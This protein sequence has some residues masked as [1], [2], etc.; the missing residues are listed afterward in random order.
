MCPANNH[1]TFHHI[2]DMSVKNASMNRERQHSSSST[3]SGPSLHS[4][5]LPKNLENGQLTPP[6]E[7]AHEGDSITDMM[8][9]F[10]HAST[11]LS[12]LTDRMKTMLSCLEER[13]NGRLQVHDTL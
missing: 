9:G 6:L 3:S 12:S 4:L 13:I 8:S 11:E 2:I 10:G 1:Q 7:S 5:Q